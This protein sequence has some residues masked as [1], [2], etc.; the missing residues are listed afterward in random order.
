M[1]MY[2]MKS[3]VTFS[4]TQCSCQNVSQQ[5]CTKLKCSKF[6]ESQNCESV[7]QYIRLSHGNFM[8]H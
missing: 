8:C 3:L 4:R 1:T 2:T 7:L 6:S 5:K